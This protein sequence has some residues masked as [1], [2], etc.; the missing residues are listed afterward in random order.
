M[1]STQPFTPCQHRTQFD[2]QWLRAVGT[3]A[4]AAY[5]NGGRHIA[6]AADGR[7]LVAAA[8]ETDTGFELMTVAAAEVL[9][10]WPLPAPPTGISL[11]SGAS[12][13]ALWYGI[14][15]TVFSVPAD[16][17]E[18]TPTAV[19]AGDLV[20]A[21]VHGAQTLL[22][23][24]G[25]PG[26]ALHAVSGDSLVASCELSAVPG[27]AD[28]E[29]VGDDVHVIFE[30]EQGLEYR[31][32]R[33]GAD[34][35]FLELQRSRCAEAYASWPT[36]LVQD[37]HI[38]VGY[39]GDDCRLPSDRT[40]CHARNRLGRG[41][42]V[43]LLIGD[44]VDWTATRAADTEQLVKPLRQRGGI[45]GGGPAVK[46][47]VRMDSFGPPAL[48]IGGDGVPTLYW[49]STERR[50]V[51]S[52]RLL[53]TELAP[54]SEVR[55]PVEQLTGPV[56]VPRRSTAGDTPVAM[57]SPAR[58]IFDRIAGA[59]RT[60]AGARQLDFCQLDELA[61]ATGLEQ[62]VESMQRHQAN[63]V[64]ACGARGEFDDG[65]LVADIERDPE[66]GGWRAEYHFLKYDPSTLETRTRI[67]HQEGFAV[68]EDGISWRKQPPQSLAERF[69]V[70]GASDGHLY[71]IRYVEDLDEAD[72]AKRYKGFWR[73]S[74][75]HPWGWAPV[76]SADRQQWKRV[77]T[78]TVIGADD[79]L[80]VW[81]DDIDVP[82]RRFKA[83]AIS[84]SFCGRVCAMWTSADGL[85]WD[86][87]RDTLD[88]E[89]PFGPTRAFPSTGRILLDSWSG[90]P[91][92]DEIHGGYVF[93][94]G[95]RW[96]LHY[97]KWT[98]DGHIWTGLA[99]SRDGLNFSRVGG[100]AAVLPLGAPG[101]WDS[102]RIA[103]RE[104]P[105]RVGDRWRQYY[106]GCGWKHG[107]G[108]AGAMTSFMGYNCPNQVGVAEQL[109]GR[110]AGLRLRRECDQ[111]ELATIEMDCP[112]PCELRLNVAGLARPGAAIAVAAIDATSGR[113][114]DRCN[115][116]DMQPLAGDGPAVAVRWRRDTVPNGRLR[117]AVR[118]QG[119]GVVL[120]GMQLAPAAAAP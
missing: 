11:V 83:S 69:T 31:H 51:Y 63:P 17:G 71:A 101:S 62:V 58:L 66:S 33:Q 92:E 46:L 6:T 2:D 40:W 114:F 116:D 72:A 3:P 35:G 80:R 43:V 13:L 111:A 26:L 107:M 20:A 1:G 76:Y 57:L 10:R 70:E 88:F 74:E 99:S 77:E 55:G 79:D 98:P 108:G 115:F 37:D 90:P 89:D 81:I 12:G 102:G 97:M 52:R 105:H 95:D 65:G 21:A 25:A 61:L 93:R 28:L 106:I 82:A 42:V 119:H 59:P 86:G 103:L 14:G 44:G 56:L 18:P 4:L 32:L 8:A 84:R 7:T 45:Y 67:W 48:G 117:L 50:W 94:D 24:S 41:Q 104:A 39:L 112:Q 64:L 60:V 36:L 85:D 15:D 110:W 68:S 120:Y 91:E 87:E 49:A 29:V 38:L 34:G 22:L 53:G 73:T 78:Q 16:G 100:G 47:R 54:A 96:L 5:T 9:A 75:H 30:F 109:A 118:L 23:V 19:S 27:R 113:A